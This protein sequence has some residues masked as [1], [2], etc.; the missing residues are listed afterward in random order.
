MSARFKVIRVSGN[1]S[2]D[3]DISIKPMANRYPDY[4]DSV[5][6]QTH[7]A[8]R[9]TAIVNTNNGPGYPADGY[10][11]LLDC[12]PALRKAGVHLIGYVHAS[13][14]TRPIASVIKDIKQWKAAYPGLEG[15]FI[16]EAVGWV[17]GAKS[18]GVFTNSRSEMDMIS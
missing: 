4:A 7:N 5:C 10:D 13:S 12:L 17:S 11:S 3:V 9:V 2:Y 18:Q 16:D 1:T 8:S 6:A 14:G 15:I